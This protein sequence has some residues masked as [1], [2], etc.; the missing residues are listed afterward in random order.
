MQSERNGER[1]VVNSGIEEVKQ[2]EP[3]RALITV[4]NKNYVHGK[5]NRRKWGKKRKIWH[6][7]FFSSCTHTTLFCNAFEF[8]FLQLFV[9][10]GCCHSQSQSQFQSFFMH[11]TIPI[12]QLQRCQDFCSALVVF[13]FALA[14][15][16]PLSI[17]IDGDISLLVCSR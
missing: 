17:L 1:V 8:P 2:E 6:L 5:E 14:S 11:I 15:L 3:E 7:I 10:F 4:I 16:N 12:C 9:P 13:F